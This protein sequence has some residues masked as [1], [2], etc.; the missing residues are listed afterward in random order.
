MF[1]R[2]NSRDNRQTGI[3]LA[4]MSTDVTR[5]STVPRIVREGHQLKVG[6]LLNTNFSFTGLKFAVLQRPEKVRIWREIPDGIR[7]V[8]AFIRS[9]QHALEC[10]ILAH[11]QHR[12]HRAKLISHY[13]L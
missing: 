1:V 4:A 3:E 12:G 11:L 7:R 2:P 13:T 6:S 5:T 9:L 10:E 8:V